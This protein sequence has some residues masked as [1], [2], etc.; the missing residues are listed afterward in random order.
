MVAGESG[1][2]VTTKSSVMVAGKGGSTDGSPSCKVVGR[3]GTG[4][5]E[6]LLRADGR[7]AK[8]SPSL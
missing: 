6:L 3:N 8:V 5:A 1:L 2:A 4:A 7:G